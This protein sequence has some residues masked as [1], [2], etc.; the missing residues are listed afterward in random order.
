MSY[1][2]VR[3][4]GSNGQNVLQF[5][6]TQ[7]NV[8]ANLVAQNTPSCLAPTTDLLFRSGFE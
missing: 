1:C 5:H 2:N 4:C 8:L 3:G 7:V 6:P